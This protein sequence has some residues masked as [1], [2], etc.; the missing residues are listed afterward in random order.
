LEDAYTEIDLFVA[1]GTF[2]EEFVASEMA[3]IEVV[4]A[5]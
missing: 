5:H 3:E 2:G 1:A 4:A